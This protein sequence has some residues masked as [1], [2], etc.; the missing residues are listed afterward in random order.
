M[1][2]YKKWLDSLSKA[3]LKAIDEAI[4]KIPDD[5]DHSWKNTPF[6]K[7]HVYFR[8]SIKCRKC[9]SV[10]ILDEEHQQFFSCAYLTMDDALS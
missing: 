6:L 3:E 10:F 8:C 5:D 2:A 1:N 9:G 7:A 4:A